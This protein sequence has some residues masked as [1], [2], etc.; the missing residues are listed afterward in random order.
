MTDKTTIRAWYVSGTRI[1]ELCANFSLPSNFVAALA[2][3]G[4]GFHA[5]LLANNLGPHILAR[6]REQ[7]IPT[8]Q[9]L[10]LEGKLTQGSRFIYQGHFYGKGL[11]ERH[12]SEIASLSEDVS[13]LLPGKRLVIEFSKNG[14][15]TATAHSRLSGSVNLFAFCAVTEIDDQQVRAV[16]YVIGDLVEPMECGI[17]FPFQHTLKLD[18]DEID[19][20]KNVDFQWRPSTATFNKLKHIPEAAVKSLLCGLL[21]EVEQPKDWGGEECDLFTSNLSVKG[22]NRVG[23]F[24]LKGPSKFHEMTPADCGKNGDQIY[25][26]FNTPA[27]VYVVQHCHKVSPAVRKTVEAYAL[28]Q[29]LRP[30]RYLIIDGYD[31]CRILKANGKLEENLK[32]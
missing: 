16:P 20:F 7:K 1:M 12:K 8:F 30:C 28:V 5:G 6:V 22:T 9:Q 27:D 19:Q 14:I 24:L 26:L 21:G 32:P 31:T 4:N 15:T 29:Y 2:S 10:A 17:D 13:Q 3:P 11:G 18:L 25:R 23:A